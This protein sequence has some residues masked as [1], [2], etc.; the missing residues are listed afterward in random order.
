MPKPNKRAKQSRDAIRKRWKKME[1]RRFSRRSARYISAYELGLSGKAAVL[2]LSGIGLIVGFL[3]PFWKN[4]VTCK[5]QF[6]RQS[7]TVIAP[8]ILLHVIPVAL[9]I[10]L[11]LLKLAL[12]KS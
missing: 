8:I 3:K 2:R 6:F 7:N 12:K 9:K 11:S 4:S 5:I 1:I 10:S